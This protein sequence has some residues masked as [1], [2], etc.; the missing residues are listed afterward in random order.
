MQKIYCNPDCLYLGVAS[1]V[2]FTAA[3]FFSLADYSIFHDYQ[4][5]YRRISIF[6]GT[7]PQFLAPMYIC[8]VC[9]NLCF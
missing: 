7:A 4:G 5:A 2:I 1:N 3:T 8:F 6:F 9:H